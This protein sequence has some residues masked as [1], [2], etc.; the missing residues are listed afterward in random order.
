MATDKTSLGRRGLLQAIG[1]GLAAASVL[2]A[3]TANAQTVA[4]VADPAAA[5]QELRVALDLAEP[6]S[7][8]EGKDYHLNLNQ[9]YH[10]NLAMDG[11]ANVASEVRQSL[12]QGAKSLL[13][14][15]HYTREQL[16]A[17]KQIIIEAEMTCRAHAEDL[18]KGA[19]TAVAA[20]TAAKDSLSQAVDGLAALPRS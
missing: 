14:D 4:Q 15:G 9:L 13:S 5:L 7:T 19:L 18:A 20:R 6:A 10:E 3:A 8:Q 11:V 1:G 12:L 17:A 2:G 16:V